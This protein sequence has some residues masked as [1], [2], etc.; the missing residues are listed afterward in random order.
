MQL[1]NPAQTMSS[2]EIADM[3]GVRHDSVKRTIETLISLSLIAPHGVDSEGAYNLGER[4][5]YI[6][7]ARVSPEATAALVDRW[8][9]LEQAVQIGLRAEQ[10]YIT[11]EDIAGMSG[12]KPTAAFRTNMDKVRRYLERCGLEQHVKREGSQVSFTKEGAALAL[13][14]L[15]KSNL[16][17]SLFSDFVKESKEQAQRLGKDSSDLSLGSEL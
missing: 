6:V 15:R 9:E 8:M 13:I 17:W 10:P 14:Y 11:A 3:T 16:E 12:T 5:T 2:V 4:T 1:I 7:V